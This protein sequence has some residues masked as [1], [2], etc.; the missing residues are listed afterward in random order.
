[1]ARDENFSYVGFDAIT[2]LL[3]FARNALLFTTVAVMLLSWTL[4]TVADR[5]SDVSVR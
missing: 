3:F 1:M 4:P 5:R 2:V